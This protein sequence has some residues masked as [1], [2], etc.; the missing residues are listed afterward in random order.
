[1]SNDMNGKTAL[2]TGSGSGIGQ[3]TA[4]AF[5]QQGA[6]VAVADIIKERADKT[7]DII[8]KQGGRA[9]PFQCDVSKRGD[10]RNCVESIVN[11]FGRL[12]FA[13]NNAGIHNS[14]T[15]FLADADEDTWDKI[16]AVNLKGVFLCM[17]YEVRVM[18]KQKS[19]VIVNMSSLS[20]LLAESGCY[21][22]SASKHGIIGLTKT[23][24]YDLAKSGIR[25]NAVCPGAVLTPG[26]AAAPDEFRQELKDKTPLG[27]LGKPEE[28]AATVLWLC[29]DTASF[30]TGT[31]IV[32][33]GGVSTV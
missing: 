11:D 30:I 8:N 25:I 24:A 19:G 23:A 22:Y 7:A 29:S 6:L 3:S 17:K 21:A 4:I 18:L 5:A 1:M 31:G 9:V 12:D 15:E 20:G 33:D 14:E 32:I 26:L 2:V 16:I 27:R 28:I 10:V 13:C